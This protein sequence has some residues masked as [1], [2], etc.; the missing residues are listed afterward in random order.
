MRKFGWEPVVFTPENPEMPAEDVSLLN[1]IPGGIEVIKNKIWE[2]YSFYKKFTGR[3]R[4]QKIQTAFL[5]EKKSNQ[6]W[7][8]RLSVWV[9]GNLFIPDARRF[10]IKPSVN[11][12]STY[13]KKNKVDAIVTTGPPHSAHLIGLGLKK[14]SGLPWLADF[15]DPWTNIDFYKELKLGKRA[16]SKHHQLE[17]MVLAK[18]DAV[19][20]ISPGMKREFETTVP[21]SYH[22]IPNGYDLDDRAEMS[23]QQAIISSRFSLAHIGSLTRTRNPEN[24]WNAL[25]QLVVEDAAFASDLEIRNIGKMDFRVAESLKAVG[26]GSYLSST[27]YLPHKEVVIEQNKAALLLLLINNTPN[28]KL[29]LTG[30]IFEYLASGRPVICIGP[31]DGDAARVI[32]ESGCGKVYGFNEIKKLKT[33]LQE[34]YNLFKRQELKAKCGNVE[35]FDRKNLTGKIAGLLD[36]II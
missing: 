27:E 22:V 17:Q 35:Q 25:S 10:W 6:G 5:S 11:L 14:Q 12:L 28:A 16:D 2:P 8:E 1:E 13:V 26:L 15:R 7:M 4:E 34:Y 31:T 3:K 18:A 20:V 19:V 29:I 33:D 30:K 21:R 9:R 24:L 23:A 32:R 36:S